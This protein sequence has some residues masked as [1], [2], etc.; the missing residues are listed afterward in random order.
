MRSWDSNNL[1]RHPLFVPVLL[2]TVI[3]S[4][5]YPSMLSGIHTIDDPGIFSLYSASPPLSQILM[6]G[7]NSYYYRPL[8]ELSYWL[9]NLL[10]GMEP[11]VMHLESIV[12]HC[13]NTL[14]VCLLA[15]KFSSSEKKLFIPLL[16]ALL[17]AVHPVNVEAVAWIA[18]RTDL[19]LAL[20]V[21]SASYF[22]L[23]W[24]DAPRLPDMV[25]TLVLFIAALLT[26]ETA[27]AFVGVIILMTYGRPG[28]TSVCQRITAVG[29]LAALP[30]ILILFLMIFR[31]GTGGL[32]RFLSSTNVQ[33]GQGGL[34]ALIAIGFYVK[35]MILPLPL[36][37]AITEVYPAYGFLGAVFLVLLWCLFYRNRLA[38]VLFAAA[39]LLCLPAVLVAV[40]Q[41]A[42]TPFA[43]RYLYLPSAFFVLGLSVWIRSNSMQL[44]GVVTKITLFIVFI[45]AFAC[46]QRSMLWSNK[47][48]FFQDAITKSPGFGSLYNELGNLRLQSGEIDQAGD[49][50]SVAD[51]LNRRD[52]MRLL[53]KA[54]LLGV[55]YV[56]GNNSKV[57]EMFFHQFKRKQ[58]APAYFLELLYKA[59]GKRINSL[60]AEAKQLL[61]EDLIETLDLL[62]QKQPDPFWLYQSGQFALQAGDKNRAADFFRRAYTAAPVDAH[63]RGAAKTLFLRL[64][65]GN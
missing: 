25:L 15:R 13:A 27:I 10:W 37:S 18:G 20:C 50:Y 5:Y 35:K 41:I 39:F 17:F 3:L 59:D 52:S 33:P 44:Q 30:L 2:V 32:S 31:S 45:S 46:L 21:L 1:L 9:D 49:A 65:Q 55:H 12:L 64:E 57:R 19:L 43:E 7:G 11:R 36:N 8:V 4:V 40:K 29:I 53:I 28:A 48:A 42:W 23:R 63:Y 51:R 6:P 60:P 26:K 38:G 61:A 54:N 58:D 14:L 16:S 22:W 56:K 24:L 47:L 62:N 34:D